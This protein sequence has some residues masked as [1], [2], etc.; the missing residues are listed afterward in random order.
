MYDS[1]LLEQV[2]AFQSQRGLHID[3]VLG[4]GTLVALNTSPAQLRD[5][6]RV[7]LERMRWVPADFFE[8]EISKVIK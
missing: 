5:K 2:Q 7:N 6:I 1:L 3:G 4:Q 8:K